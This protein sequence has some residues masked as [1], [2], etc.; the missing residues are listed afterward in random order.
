MGELGSNHWMVFLRCIR[1]V[2]ENKMS[3]DRSRVRRP[4]D[5]VVGLLLILVYGAALRMTL[6]FLRGKCTRVGER[7]TLR[8]G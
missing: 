5:C 6:R 1:G 8:A 4:I 2:R 3:H 7:G